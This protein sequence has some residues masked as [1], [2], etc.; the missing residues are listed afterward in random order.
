MR[1]IGWEP[2]GGI[3]G[4]PVS[5]QASPFEFPDQGLHLVTAE[6]GKNL[7]QFVEF[8]ACAGVLPDVTQ[9]ERFVSVTVQAALAGVDT[10]LAG[11]G[12]EAP[13]E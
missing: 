3:G 5:Y 10:F 4:A 11:L 7:Q 8:G 6:G 13:A 9:E 1:F 2:T 12:V